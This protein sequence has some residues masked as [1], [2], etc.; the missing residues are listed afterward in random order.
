MTHRSTEAALPASTVAGQ[1][2]LARL[3]ARAQAISARGVLTTA[4]HT[5]TVFGISALALIALLMFRPDLGKQL[6]HSLFPLPMAEAQ[7][8]EA[9]ALSALMEA[10]ASVQTAAASD[11]PLS[12]EEKALLGTQKQ[13]QWVTNWLSKRYRVAND[14]TNMLV[15]T[16]YLTAREIKLD[17]LLILAVM[18]IESGLN[19]FAESPSARKA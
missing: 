11:A 12:K 17:P 14:A 4:Q 6:T 13:Q 1:P 19:P 5:L 15:S 16:A 9:P 18:A 2:A 3:R 10:P 8:V 7:A